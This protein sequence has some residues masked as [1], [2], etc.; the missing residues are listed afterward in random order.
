MR[1]TDIDMDTSGA[2]RGRFQ[3][4][5]LGLLLELDPRNYS[6]IPVDTVGFLHITRAV[7][8]LQ[9]WQSHEWI[10]RHQTGPPVALR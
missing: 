10:R 4:L 7:E 5:E 9:G 3:S 1:V 2:P 6:I 8:G